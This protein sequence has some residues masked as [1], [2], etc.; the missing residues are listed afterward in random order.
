MQVQQA[1]IEVAGHNMA[2]VNNPAYARQRIAIQ[3]SS[4]IR[5]EHGW[6]GTGADVA[7]VTQIRNY[8]LDNQITLEGSVTGSLEAQQ[9]ALQYAQADLGQQIDRGATGAE[10]AA[11]AAGTGKQHG[12]GDTISELFNQ[13]QSLSLQPSSATE[14]DLVLTK[15][16]QLAE[17]FQQTDQRLDQLRESLNQTV[18]SDVDDVNALLAD[19]AKLNRQIGDAEAMGDATANDIRDTRQA[20]ADL[21]LAR[22]RLRVAEQ[23]EELRQRI[24]IFASKRLDAGDA[25]PQEVATAK[26]DS[27]TAKQDVTRI[28]QDVALAEERLRNLLGLSDDRTTLNPTDPVPPIRGEFD[29]DVL[30]AEAVSSRPDLL[31]VEIGRA[32]V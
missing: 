22:G 20:Y 5:T 28:R 31:A 15:A 25:T 27:L 12:I 3:T 1:G 17:R 8:L 18:S 10:G 7:R 23:A 30:S 14:R 29:V 6:E 11:A 24:T 26:I 16:S 13:F 19:I 4:P 9:Q 2:N 21:Q 32:H